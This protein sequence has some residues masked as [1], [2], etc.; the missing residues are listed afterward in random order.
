MSHETGLTIH[1]SRL[2]ISDYI[3][4]LKNPSSEGAYDCPD[5]HPDT[6]RRS[7]PEILG[8]DKPVATGANNFTV[9]AGSSTCAFPITVQQLPPNLTLNT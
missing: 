3:C 6:Y 9:T 5:N 4:C 2:T 1:D 8:K 7:N